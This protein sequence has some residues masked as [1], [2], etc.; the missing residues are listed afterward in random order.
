M[1]QCFSLSAEGTLFTSRRTE[2]PGRTAR[3]PGNSL[4]TYFSGDPQH[5]GSRRDLF[6]LGLETWATLMNRNTDSL[7]QKV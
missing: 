2:P 6:S 7:N 4:D 1:V 5:P 3:M